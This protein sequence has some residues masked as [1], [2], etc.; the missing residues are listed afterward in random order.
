[1]CSGYS[2]S[3]ED[4]QLDISNTE[5]SSAQSELELGGD[6]G[7]TG[8]PFR[9]QHSHSAPHSLQTL[10]ERRFQKSGVYGFS[11][12]YPGQLGWEQC[13]QGGNTGCIRKQF[14]RKRF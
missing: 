10:Q 11:F 6:Y 5:A 8:L 2:W 7:Q 3:R 12:G 14:E 13:E 1:M 4:Q 9:G